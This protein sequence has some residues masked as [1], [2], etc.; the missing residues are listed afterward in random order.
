MSLPVYEQR[1]AFPGQ[2]LFHLLVNAINIHNCFSRQKCK[3]NIFPT[4][5]DMKGRIQNMKKCL[6]LLHCFTHKLSV[7]TYITMYRLSLS[8][9]FQDFPLIL[10]IVQKQIN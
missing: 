5:E 3:D 6:E 8:H 4:A 2:L 1:K 7:S 10:F 9:C